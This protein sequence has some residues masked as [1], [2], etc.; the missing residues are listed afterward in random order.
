V[1]YNAVVNRRP[2]MRKGKLMNVTLGQKIVD[3]I[4]IGFV[5]YSV[6]FTLWSLVSLCLKGW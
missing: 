5:I 1:G 6:C 3:A 4:V 2:D